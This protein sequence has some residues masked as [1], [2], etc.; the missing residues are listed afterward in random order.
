MVALHNVNGTYYNADTHPRLI[1]VLEAARELAKKYNRDKDIFGCRIQLVYGDKDTGRI[2]E[3]C[4]PSV[5]YV[6]R[7]TGM[8]AIP[9][10]IR[11]RT[12]MGGEA[13]LDNSILQVRTS[14]LASI[15]WDYRF[16]ELTA[17]QLLWKAKKL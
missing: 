6:G 16:P 12:S 7:S 15:L 13:I 9:L 10:L 17:N 1:T 4:T 14:R 8:N 3:E 5:G 2:W 11:N